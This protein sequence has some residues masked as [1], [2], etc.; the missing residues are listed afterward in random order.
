MAQRWPGAG[1]Q[2]LVAEQV[3]AQHGQ[4][5]LLAAGGG[6]AVLLVF[7]FEDLGGGLGLGGAFT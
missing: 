6:Q 7:G 1:V 4:G 3:G 5:R 2:P